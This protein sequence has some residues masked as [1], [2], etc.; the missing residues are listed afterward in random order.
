[1]YTRRQRPQRRA[2][3]LGQSFAIQPTQQAQDGCCSSFPICYY[4]ELAEE[5]HRI[6]P[7]IIG[8]MTYVLGT[9]RKQ[10]VVAREPNAHSVGAVLL[11]ESK[12]VGSDPKAVRLPA[13]DVAPI[14]NAAVEP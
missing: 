8:V 2:S 10:R 13:L 9:S 4:A 11:G 3:V 6:V 1:M 7:R 12:R 14:M 5:P